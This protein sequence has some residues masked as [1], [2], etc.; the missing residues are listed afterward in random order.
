MHINKENTKNQ[1]SI[2]IPAYNEEQ[3]IGIVIDN[4]LANIALQNMDC[5]IIVVDD[6]SLDKTAEIV[7][8]YDVQLIQHE[9][10][11][12]Y[13]ASLKTGI[14]YAKYNVIVITDADGTYPIDQIP[15]LVNFINEYD[16]VVGARIGKHVK[17]PLIRQPIKWFL[18]KYANYLVQDNIPD[19]NSGLRVFKKDVFKKF[20][21]ILPNGFSFTTTIT[22]ALLSDGYR[23]KYMP[24]NYFKRG[25]KSKIRPIRDTIN[26]FSLITKVSLYFNPLRVFMPIS[27]LLLSLGVIFLGYDIWMR[28]ITDKT[29]MAFLWGMQFGILGFLADMISQRR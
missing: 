23:V 12:G 2:I 19:L 11:K 5:E 8:R 21:G 20:R 25:G 3:R 7:K 14:Y 15:K 22:L 1:I 9:H 6:G 16:M 4:L 13:G 26:F 24:I 18:N 28:D 27:F 10:N 29:M 17:I